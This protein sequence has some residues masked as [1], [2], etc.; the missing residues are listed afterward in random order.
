MEGRAA[1]DRLGGGQGRPGG[2]ARDLRHEKKAPAEQKIDNRLKRPS[3]FVCK[4]RF[5]NDLPEPASQ[6]K[7]LQ[8][9]QDRDRYTKYSVTSLEKKYK[10]KLHVEPD[11]GIPLDLLDMTVYDAPP[12]HARPPLDPADEELLRDDMVV[13]QEKGGALKVKE[14]PTDKGLNWL[15]H[16]QYISPLDTDEVP[17]KVRCPLPPLP[18]LLRLLVLLHFSLSSPSFPLLLRLLI[19]FLLRLLRL[20]VPP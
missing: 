10:Y 3:T 12:A 14:R 20:R 15:V 19:R 1:L 18:L 6:L 4:V 13:L 16:T 8:I 7:L 17:K 11:L 9:N 2:S 5:R